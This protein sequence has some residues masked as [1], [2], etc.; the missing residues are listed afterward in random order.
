M[1]RFEI[2]TLLLLD[3]LFWIQVA[4]RRPVGEFLTFSDLFLPRR[5]KPVAFQAS[6]L[7]AITEDGLVAGFEVCPSDS[8]QHVL[9]L[10]ER[11]YRPPAGE[12]GI[13]ANDMQV[14]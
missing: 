4:F 2:K 9:G 13:M 10:I 7:T 1:L 5:P 6:L 3:P 11:L 14:R 8:H 12:G